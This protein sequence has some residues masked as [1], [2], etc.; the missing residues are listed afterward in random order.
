MRIAM[1]IKIGPEFR[2]LEIFVPELECLQ[3]KDKIKKGQNSSVYNKRARIS[4][5]R[6]MRSKFQ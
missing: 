6:R 4:M 5:S 2:C 1:F 3:G